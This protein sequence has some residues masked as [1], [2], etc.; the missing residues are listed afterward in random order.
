MLIIVV[1]AVVVFVFCTFG[2]VFA[3]LTQ[4]AKTTPS[5]LPFFTC[6]PVCLASPF[7]CKTNGVFD[8]VSHGKYVF[9]AIVAVVAVVDLRLGCDRY[10]LYECDVV[11][12]SS[13]VVVLAIDD[14]VFQ[15]MQ[16]NV[17]VDSR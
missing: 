5:L 17:F 6:C 7:D 16:E 14:D 2:V 12:S 1:C 15:Q 10:G 13:D 8:K 9:V 11:L 3:V 4:I